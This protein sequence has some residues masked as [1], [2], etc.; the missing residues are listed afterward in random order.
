MLIA[1]IKINGTLKQV[2]TDVKCRVKLLGIGVEQCKTVEGYNAYVN[3]LQ[4]ETGIIELTPQALISQVGIAQFRKENDR[5]FPAMNIADFEILKEVEAKDI[6]YS[7]EIAWI[8][9]DENLDDVAIYLGDIV[10]I[11]IENGQYLTSDVRYDE[12]QNKFYLQG[13]S[14]RYFFFI[15]CEV[16]KQEV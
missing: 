9:Q 16:E 3:S 8:Y 14:S 15:G 10:K 13:V 1:E 4:W 6:D 11:K 12:E 2:Y 5:M 7:K